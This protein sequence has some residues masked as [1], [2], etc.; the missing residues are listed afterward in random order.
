ML[1]LAPLTSA[2]R[3][4]G[5]DL[6]RTVV[7]VACPGCGE[8]DTVLCD[9][10]A[11][12]WWAAPVRAEDC[13]PRLDVL[14]RA[15]LPV[16]SLAP[17]VGSPAGVITAWKDGRRRDLDR[18]MRA[19]MSRAGSAVAV[20][21]SN[22][23][24]RRIHVV[25]A[26]ARAASTRRRGVDLPLLLA[27]G[28][29]EGVASVLGA[30]VVRVA[31]C[32]RIGVGESR[33]ASARGRWRNASTAVRCARAPLEPVLLVDDVL[34]TG[35]TLAACVNAIE[36]SGGSVIAGLTAAFVDSGRATAPA[37]LV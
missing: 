23:G 13:A 34:T 20:P 1:S 2:L 5:A 14:D 16:W 8:E 25:P 24:F 11:E 6:A 10:C 26:P 27:S 30:D 28:A 32:L 22:S 12:P 35:A 15:P 3:R 7:P 36:Q 31:R 37:G 18:M 29:A 9:A 17:L 19:A 21:L 4:A 33:G